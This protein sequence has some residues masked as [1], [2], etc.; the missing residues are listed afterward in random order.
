MALRR[1]R[2]IFQQIRTE[3]G[4][5]WDDS[6]HWSLPIFPSRPPAAR[7]MQAS[8]CYAGEPVKDAQYFLDRGDR[9]FFRSV[10]ERALEEYS[11]AVGLDPGSAPAWQGQVFSLIE[12]GEYHEAGLWYAN[13]AGV[14]G[15]TPDLLARGRWRRR[16]PVSSTAPAGTRIR[17]WRK[18]AGR[19]PISFAGSCFS[20]RAGMPSTA[21]SRRSRSAESRSGKRRFWWPT[22][23]CSRIPTLRPAWR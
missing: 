5:I 13:A 6:T 1:M 4:A 11:R 14:I 9:L 22:A 18:A 7:R 21:S 15:E 12:L 23:V 2:S 17:R 20:I 3:N 16:A 8:P 10:Y 19:S